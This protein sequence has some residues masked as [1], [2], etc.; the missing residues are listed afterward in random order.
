MNADTVTLN[1]YSAP[2][3]IKLTQ[4][5]LLVF[6]ETAQVRFPRSRR[7]R[8][9]RKWA[10]RSE[11]FRETKFTG[12][13]KLGCGYACHPSVLEELRRK[14]SDGIYAD[15]VAASDPEF[16]RWNTLLGAGLFSAP[17]NRKHLPRTASAC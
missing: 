15:V 1:N 17:P 11:N 7:S 16:D 2:L 12:I 8:I 5:P 3:P 13:I 14:V 10:K 9:R 4:D 6:S